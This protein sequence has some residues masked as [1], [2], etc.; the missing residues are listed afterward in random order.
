MD[1]PTIPAH[2]TARGPG[3][4][5]PTIQK[6]AGDKRPYVIDLEPLLQ[7]NELAMGVSLV[8]GT[9]VEVESARTR[10]GRYLELVVGGGE[11]A[12][13]KPADHL[14]SASVTTTKGTVTVR[15]SFRVHP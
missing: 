10:L 4:P 5:A 7:E 9:S 6:L 3:Q 8:G 14:V 12:G 15:V 1:L 13:D 11:P 2:A